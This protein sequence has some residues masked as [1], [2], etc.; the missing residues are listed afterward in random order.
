[1]TSRER[2]QNVFAH[3]I[4]DRVPVDLSGRSSAIEDGAYADLKRYLGMEDTSPAEN[5]IRSHAV[6]SEEILEL[7]QVD[8]RYVR[9]VPP[10]SWERKPDGEYFTDAWNVPWKKAEGSA[11]YDI[12]R[13]IHRD[14]ES[15]DIDAIAWPELLSDAM[16]DDITAQAR[17]LA[18]NTGYSVITDTLGSA[19]FET[20]WYMRG[21]E[22]FL[23]DMMTDEVFAM[24]YLTKIL[25]LQISAYDK[26]LTRAGAFIDAVFV[27]DDLASQDSLLMSSDLYR[28]VIAPYH[29][30]LFSFIQSKG[31]EI[32]Y[33]SCGA[34]YS[35]L[36]DLVESGVTVLHPVQLSAA[37][38]DAKVLRAEFGSRI[39]F[40][41][42]GCNSQKTLQFGTVQEVR[43]EVKQRLELLAPGGGYIFAPEHCIQPG[44]PPENIVAMF[45]T[46]KEC[47][48]Y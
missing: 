26:L 18:E 27:T 48:K 5:F 39:V 32:I 24:K 33:H 21:F 13:F 2:V 16:A 10:A 36:K 6:V 37:G 17:S 20:A 9:S 42:G 45:E 28:R 8:T 11:Y 43:D 12:S 15:E 41:G 19:M 38:M 7:F 40:W 4:P 22:Q 47:G 3:K 31:T 29:K 46:V 23:V 14:I 34:V 25:E 35:L 30:E 1:M 44:T